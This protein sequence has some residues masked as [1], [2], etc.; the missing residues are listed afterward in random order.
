LMDC[1]EEVDIDAIQMLC[2]EHGSTV[3]LAWSLQECGSY[4]CSLLK[5]N[6]LQT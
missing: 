1:P 5:C 2:F 4:I 6:N 3:Y